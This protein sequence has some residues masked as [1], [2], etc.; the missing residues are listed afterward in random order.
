[1]NSITGDMYAA[2]GDAFRA[3]TADADVR[4][5]V[6]LGDEAVFSAGND[7]GDFLNAPENIG[8]LPAAGFLR[9]ISECPKPVVAGVCGAAVG[10]G[11]TM[12][13]HCDLVVAGENAVLSLPFANLG[14]CPEAASSYL[15]PKLLGHRRASQ[16]LML[17]ARIDAVEAERFGL[18]NTVVPV[19]EVNAAADK[20]ARALA[21][22]P[23]DALI[24][25]KRLMKLDQIEPVRERM[26]TEFTSFE[27]LLREPAAKE[28]L[29]A[30]TQG[31]KPDFRSVGQ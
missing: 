16:M 21:A 24:E 6:L 29:T 2:L 25:T 23:K 11:T 1:M 30:F 15:L 12:L 26:A 10:I 8:E 7:I 19:A 4:V 20:Y 18:I 31:R 17:G 28:A 13:L 22:Q 14:L 3:A 5:I 27:R 9:A